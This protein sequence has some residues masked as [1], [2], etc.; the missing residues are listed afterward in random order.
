MASEAFSK[1][2][3]G[4]ATEPLNP[5]YAPISLFVYNRPEHTRR[6]VDALRENSEAKATDLYVFSDA[7]RSTKDESGVSNVRS[8]LQTV[9]GFK[10]VRITLRNQNLGTDQNVIDG[11]TEILEY[12]N[13]VIVIEDDIIT[14]GSFLQYM[15]AALNRY[16]QEGRVFSVS[17]YSHP[18]A[19]LRMPRDYRHSVYFSPRNYSGAWG[20]WRDRWMKA[21]WA[22]RDLEAFMADRMAVKRFNAAGEDMANL[23]IRLEEGRPKHWDIRWSY[24]HFVHDAVSVCPVTSLVNNIGHDGSGM[25][26]R[27]TSR[28]DVDLSRGGAIREFPAEILVDARILD[29]IRNVYKK[30]VLGK[31]KA[32]V[33]REA[34]RW[35]RRLL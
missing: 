2:Q 25:H 9:V 30:S 21:D 10:S 29:S 22:V 17:A 3:G 31:I 15:N 14:S 18:P 8:Y 19:I 16:A 12:S 24:A 34:F 32:L 33:Q 5:L 7:P 13:R 20:T 26:S 1:R 27:V 4:S 28:F 11:V 23:L 35:L 6:T